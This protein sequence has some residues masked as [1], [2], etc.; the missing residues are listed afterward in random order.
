MKGLQKVEKSVCTLIHPMNGEQIKIKQENTIQK[1]TLMVCKQ[2][3]D[4]YLHFASYTKH[5][6]AWIDSRIC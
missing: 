6:A 1:Q 3:Q 4:Y 2:L 5:K